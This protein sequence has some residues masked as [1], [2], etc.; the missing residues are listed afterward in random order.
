MTIR[1]RWLNDSINDD[2][3]SQEEFHQP[4]DDRSGRNI[5]M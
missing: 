1:P 3:N 2:H 5:V 4:D